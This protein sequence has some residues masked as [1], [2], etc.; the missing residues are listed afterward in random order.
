M[1]KVIT[2]EVNDEY[3]ANLKI[4]KR[5]LLVLQG[6]CLIPQSVKDEIDG[7]LG[8]LDEIQDKAIE[9]GF[10]KH[11]VF[12]LFDDHPKGEEGHTNEYIKEVNSLDV[13]IVG[14]YNKLTNK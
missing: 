2:I 1:K 7:L 5:L 14:L 12:D 9:E 3:L 4:Q 6:S 8:C 13:K 11:E 10:N